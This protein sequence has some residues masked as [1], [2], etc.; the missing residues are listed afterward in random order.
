VRIADSKFQNCMLSDSSTAR[1]PIST[2]EAESITAELD[3]WA[4]SSRKTTSDIGAVAVM[5]VVSVVV[6]SVA[7][8]VA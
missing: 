2:P 1:V 3:W 5:V 7:V 6:V 4:A 8:S